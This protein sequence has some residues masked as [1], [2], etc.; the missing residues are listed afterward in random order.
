MIIVHQVS[1]SLSIVNTAST[2]SG[3]TRFDKP[4]VSARLTVVPF[5]E[6]PRS[7]GISFCIE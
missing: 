5:V 3:S 2:A 7:A 6:Q 1:P 4:E